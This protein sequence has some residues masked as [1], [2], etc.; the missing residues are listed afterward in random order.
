MLWSDDL[1][2]PVNLTAPNPARMADYARTLG[3]V[4][5]RPAVLNV[6]DSLVRSLAG[7]VADEMALKSARVVPQKLQES[8]YDFGYERLEGGLRHLLGRVED[9]DAPM[10]IP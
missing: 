3:G 6:P 10:L 9:P 4:L 2:G 1:R 8:G 5:N 7:E